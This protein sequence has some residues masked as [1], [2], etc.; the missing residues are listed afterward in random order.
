MKI[1]WIVNSILSRLSLNL[2]NKPSNGLWMDALLE[3]FK[4]KEGF[5][6]IVAT[7][8]KTN[9]TVKIADGNITYYALPDNVPLLYNENKKCNIR[10]WQSLLDEEKPDLIQVWGTEFTHGLCALRVAKNIPSVIYMQG[11]VGSIARYYQADI[12]YTDIKKTKTFRDFVKRDGILQQ[13]QKLYRQTKKE[14]EMLKLSGRIICEN[15]WCESNLKAIVPELKFYRLP[16]SI[17]KV[18]SDYRWILHNT[19][20]FSVICTASGYTIKGL[21]MLLKAIA[22]VKQKYPEVK[23]YV[24]G[25]PQV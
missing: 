24:P 16:L 14:A 6:I 19:E 17:N 20:N 9:K 4:N 25:T 5:E 21:H 18:F 3:D 10:A 1:L 8:I 2:Y 7:T 15:T 23:L 13:Q 11:Y 22:V 12:P